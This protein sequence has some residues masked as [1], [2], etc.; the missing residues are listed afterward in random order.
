MNR[1]EIL[2]RR[3]AE[4]EAQLSVARTRHDDAG[5]GPMLKALLEGIAER[6]L[7][8]EMLQDTQQWLHFA[9]VVGGVAS[10]SVD[11]ASKT[12]KWSPATMVMYGYDPG[13]EITFERWFGAIH[14]DDREAVGKVVAATFETGSDVDQRFRIVRPDGDIRYIQDKGRVLL[15]ANGRPARL[16]GVNIDITDLAEMQDRLRLREDFLRSVIAATT[17]C[18]KIIELDGTISFV[19]SNSLEAL[20]FDGPDEIH[21]RHWSDFWPAAVQPAME[22]AIAEA[23]AGRQARFEGDRPGK[24]GDIRHWDVVLSPIRNHDGEV[25][26]IAA[27]LRDMTVQRDEQERNRLVARELHHRI[28]NSLATAQAIARSTVASSSTLDEFEVSFSARLA[29]MAQLHTL[30]GD[31]AED[32]QRA[33]LG[34]IIAAQMR[35]FEGSKAI[36]LDGPDILLCADA[37]IALGMIVHELVTNACKHGGLN[38]DGDGLDV[39]WAM[40]GNDVVLDW[41]ERGG[42]TTVLVGSGG[43][44]SR[45]IERLVRASLRGT[46]DR[47]ATATGFSARLRFPLS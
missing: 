35:P 47:E 20:G 44:G 13:S 16:I 28:R 42:G 33:L 30:L 23:A 40:D 9:Q 11:F 6:R 34:A 45:L 39:T 29:T 12:N 2:E 10:Y 38:A 19:S 41:R 3:I 7:V 43:F 27:V 21:G 22:A 36:A 26:C 14:P 17:D 4:L 32:G 1:I 31:R 25:S 24:D 37:V 46:I 8:E 5:D 18:I 15:D